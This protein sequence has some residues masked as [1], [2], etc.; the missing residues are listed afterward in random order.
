MNGPFVTLIVPTRDRESLLFLTIEKA[1]EAF[2]DIPFEL[3]VVNDSSSD[4][5]VPE[6]LRKFVRVIRNQGRGV[7]SA[8]NTG[9]TF[10]SAKWL[11]FLD[12]D[13]WLNV[14]VV[15]RMK[16]I[17]EADKEVIY[18]FNW[19]YP[20]YLQAE[21]LKSP[22]GRFL[23]SIG[24]T[25]M[26][27]WC[28]GYS[29]RDNEVFPAQGLAGATL[30]IPRSVYTRV[31]GYDSSFPLAG[32]EDYD[33]SQRIFKSGVPCF[34]DAT[35]TAYHN[36]VNKTVL[37]GFLKRTYDNAITRAHGVGIGYDDHRLYF[38]LLKRVVFTLFTPLEGSLRSVLTYW[39][40]YAFFDP[41]YYFLCNR[42][43]GFYIYKGYIAGL[44][45]TNE[46]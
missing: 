19:I 21:I 43:I 17:V 20:S 6:Q 33:F 30:L 11:W 5:Q 44:A 31:N 45:N 42:L 13:M 34:I 46:K 24:F 39:P 1:I 27:G 40:N 37:K 32:F 28:K 14:P 9:A 22:F 10:A 35:V 23:T 38:P 7:A 12:D 4:L 16:S 8:R 41:I 29:W 26:K 18:N 25:T 2:D 3:I 36:E 15:R